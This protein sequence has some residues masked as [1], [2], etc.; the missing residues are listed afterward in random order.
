MAYRAR[1]F[2][3]R[4]SQ[5]D[6]R[7]YTNE[8]SWA[9]GLASAV[10]FGVRF[11]FHQPFAY[12]VGCA[13]FG[14]AGAVE[15]WTRRG[16][17]AFRAFAALFVLGVTAALLARPHGAWIGMEDVVRLIAKYQPKPGRTQR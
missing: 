12:T 11:V 16:S 6:R 7:L 13:L 15:A 2:D 17:V 14:V 10:M 8:L 5:W 1:S 4:P 3:R 9:I